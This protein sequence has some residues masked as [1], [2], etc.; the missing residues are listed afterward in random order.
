MMHYFMSLYHK[1]PLIS[2]S[3]SPRRKRT[4]YHQV[5]DYL[6]I[7]LTPFSKGD[8]QGTAVETAG[9]LKELK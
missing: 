3:E 6:K 7:P 4:G 9:Y 1:V 2:M 5:R 8:L